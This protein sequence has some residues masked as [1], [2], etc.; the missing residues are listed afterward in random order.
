LKVVESAKHFQRRASTL[1]GRRAAALAARGLLLRRRT[2]L[3]RAAARAR[4]LAAASRSAR[5]VGD[6]RRPL[7]GHALVLE[8]LVLLLVLNAWSLVRHRRPPSSRYSKRFPRARTHETDGARKISAHGP[9]A[10]HAP[11]PAGLD[12]VA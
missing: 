10:A 9:A 1:L 7:L 4:L 2:A 8:R 12:E 3:L 5:R 11:R 6:P